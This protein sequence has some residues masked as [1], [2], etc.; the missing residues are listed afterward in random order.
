MPVHDRRITLTI[1]CHEDA[2]YDCGLL[3]VGVGKTRQGAVVK[4][5][6]LC[7]NHTELFQQID[8]ELVLDGWTR[9]H[10]GPPVRKF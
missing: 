3:G 6:E 7:E 5:F 2:T 8:L 10:T 1:P 4:H 9:S